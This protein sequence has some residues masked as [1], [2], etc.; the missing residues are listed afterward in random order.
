MLVKGLGLAVC[1]SWEQGLK[2]NNQEKNSIKQLRNVSS[3]PDLRGGYKSIE[4]LSKRACSLPALSASKTTSFDKEAAHFSSFFLGAEV[5]PPRTEPV[6]Q[7]GWDKLPLSIDASR[8]KPS[9]LEDLRFTELLRYRDGENNRHIF[10][11]KLESCSAEEM[12]GV[13]ALRCDNNGKYEFRAGFYYDDV[14]ST[15]IHEKLGV[16]RKSDQLYVG[17][18]GRFTL[19]Y[20]ALAPGIRRLQAFNISFHYV[21]SLTWVSPAK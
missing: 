21:P 8:G 2:E 14:D 10:W 3:E 11:G 19:A 18:I 15:P 17:E 6:K 5:V 4:T 16:R 7:E 9:P 13:N 20:N 1:G 12:H